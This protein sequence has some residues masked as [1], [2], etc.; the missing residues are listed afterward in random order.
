MAKMAKATLIACVENYL[1]IQAQIKVLEKQADD[2]KKVLRAEA[3]KA[4]AGTIVA[5][6]HSI[7]LTECTRNSIDVKEFTAAHPKLAEKY[8]KT[9]TY[10]MLKVK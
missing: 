1:D 8:T 3:E 10:T 7:T 6:E 5:G 9:T 2:L 4:P